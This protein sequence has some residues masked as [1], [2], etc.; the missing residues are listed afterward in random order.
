[1]KTAMPIPTAPIDTRRRRTSTSRS[2]LGKALISV[3][4]LMGVPPSSVGNNHPLVLRLQSFSPLYLD[5]LRIRYRR[6]D[7]AELPLERAVERILDDLEQENIG[8]DMQPLM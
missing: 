5:C 8:L 6:G 7:H 4:D 3:A 2:T 1:M